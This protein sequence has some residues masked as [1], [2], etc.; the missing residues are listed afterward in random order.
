MPDASRNPSGQAG[1]WL[2]GIHFSGF[3]IVMM[4]LLV[5]AV[6]VLAPALHE[7]V[8]QRQQITDARQ[9]VS[10]LKSQISKMD[11]ERARWSD[12]SYIRA[13]ARERLYYVMPGDISYLI[14]DDRPASEKNAKHTP[15][16][17]KI[18]STQSDWSASLFGSFMTAGLTDETPAELSKDSGSV[19]TST[20]TPS[21][22]TTPSPHTTPTPSTTPT[23]GH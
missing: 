2:R 15:V 19:P 21:P 18:Q 13:Q 14:I 22:R 9:T 10:D 3:S 11:Q 8:Q 4:A 16:S 6:V 20:S 23:A 7:Y 17:T 12:P 5:L 1:G